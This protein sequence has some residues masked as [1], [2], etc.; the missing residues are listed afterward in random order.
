ME[1]DKVV[2]QRPLRVFSGVRE[3]FL[4]LP[5]VVGTQ[6]HRWVIIHPCLAG[7]WPLVCVAPKP[8]FVTRYIFGLLCIL[9]GFVLWAPTGRV[10][11]GAGG[12]RV[13][14]GLTGTPEF[15]PLL[16]LPLRLDQLRVPA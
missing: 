16:I 13:E 12:L 9:R 11:A 8:H 14:W 10:E 1:A 6:I 4:I 2:G 3:L 5:T 15:L 7:I